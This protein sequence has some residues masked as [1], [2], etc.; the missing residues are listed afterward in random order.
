VSGT[1]A[2]A[3]LPTPYQQPPYYQPPAASYP[4][5]PPAAGP[6]YGYD[7]VSGQLLSDKSKI[8]AGLLQLLPGVFCSLGGIGR[9]YAGHTALG[10]AQLAA[11]FVAWTAAV[12]ASFTFGLTLIFTVGAWLWFLI[13]GIVLLAGRPVDGQ[14]RPLRT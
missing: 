2:T 7:P 5:Q 6:S 8:V 14:G 3:P 11:S 9:L 1:P 4:Y 12:C 10:I 13:D